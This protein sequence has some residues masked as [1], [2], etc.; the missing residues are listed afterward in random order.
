[1][2]VSCNRL[3]MKQL[4][5]Y[6]SDTRD[7]SMW[8]VRLRNA[9][10][11]LNTYSTRGISVCELFVRRMA[12][13]DPSARHRSA[14]EEKCPYVEIKHSWAPVKPPMGT[15]TKVTS[16][17]GAY[18]NSGPQAPRKGPSSSWDRRSAS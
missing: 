1:M 8:A 13:G 11:S 7:L 17:K 12:A 4:P 2:F 10:N 16:A 5:E 14:P 3:Y 18:P 6:L 9:G 15:K